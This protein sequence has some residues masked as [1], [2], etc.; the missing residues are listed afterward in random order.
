MISE[1]IMVR[2][3]QLLGVS[4]GSFASIYRSQQT[5]TSLPTNSIALE[6]RR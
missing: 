6:S 4:T 2:S 1:V 5:R 3:V